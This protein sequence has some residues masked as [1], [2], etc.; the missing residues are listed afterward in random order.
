MKNEGCI[1]NLK[2]IIYGDVVNAMSHRVSNLNGI[3]FRRRPF[4][5]VSRF[6]KGVYRKMAVRLDDILNN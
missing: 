2:A 1:E 5:M 3:D 4:F 6:F